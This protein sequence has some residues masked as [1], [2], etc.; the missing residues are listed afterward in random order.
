[1][2]VRANMRGLSPILDVRDVDA[3]L[4]WYVERLGFGIAFRYERDPSNYAGVYRDGVC[5]HM[6]WQHEREFAAGTAGPTRLRI[7]VDDPDALF[8]EYQAAGALDASARVWDTDW[9]TREFTVLDRDRNALAF[10]RDR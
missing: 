2:P 9:G 6:Q 3:A 7:E 4:A 5:L 10:W 1:M 8:A